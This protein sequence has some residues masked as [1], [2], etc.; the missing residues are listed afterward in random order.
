MKSKW[1]KDLKAKPEI[2]KLLEENLGGKLLD[3]S[4]GNDLFLSHFKIKTKHRLLHQTTCCIGKEPL[5]KM[6]Q[7]PTE[8]IWKSCI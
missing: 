1:V 4:L 7:Q 3:I 2:I 8:N 6:N 5:N